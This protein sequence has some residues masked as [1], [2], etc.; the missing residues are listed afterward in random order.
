MSTA[1]EFNY[2]RFI[3]KY[4]D[5]VLDVSKYAEYGIII[6]KED[7]GGYRRCGNS[8]VVSDNYESFYKFMSELGNNDKYIKEYK[9]TYGTKSESYPNTTLVLGDE[10]EIGM[11][12]WDSEHARKMFGETV[13]SRENYGKKYRREF[14]EKMCKYFCLDVD[15]NHI[16]PHV[17]RELTKSQNHQKVM[18]IGGKP[19]SH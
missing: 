6:P 9:S 15:E 8:P 12:R 13:L 18:V 5:H 19:V 10:E 14:S 16:G 3:E 4:P 11:S 7:T 17:I 2:N 1:I